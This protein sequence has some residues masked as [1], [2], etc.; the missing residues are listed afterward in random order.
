MHRLFQRDLCKLRL[1]TARAY[2]KVISDGHG[3]L[4]ATGTTPLRLDAKV[5]GLGPN[6]K[7][8]LTL[9]NTGIKPLADTPITFLYNHQFY[10]IQSPV[11][12]VSVAICLLLLS[13]AELTRLSFDG[14][15]GLMSTQ[16]P[17]L[18]PGLSYQ[19]EVDVVSIEP[20][21]RP[22]PIR[23]FVCN[24]KSTVPTISAI[25]TS[26]STHLICLPAPRLSTLLSFRFVRAVNMPQSELPDKE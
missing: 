15:D 17:L 26:H 13:F 18:I 14:V 4:S 12:K 8:K 7:L 21:G 1:S 9:K 25:G 3:P 22:D 6:F 10:Q 19:F 23:V 5:A 20:Q 24:A 16:I 11:A 2:V